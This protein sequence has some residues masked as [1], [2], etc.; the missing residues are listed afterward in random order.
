MVTAG[1]ACCVLLA[2]VPDC[3]SRGL[4]CSRSRKILV[5]VTVVVNVLFIRPIVNLL[6]SHFNHHPFILLNDIT[7]FILTVPTFVLVGDGI[8]NLVFTKLLVLTIVL[9]YF[10]NIV[11]SALPTVF[12]ARVHCDTLTTTFGVSILITNLA[13]AL[14]T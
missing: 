5:V 11:T 14:T 3:L 12:P 8:V 1:I 7:L 6:D 9:G 13:P 4:R 10:A 2:C